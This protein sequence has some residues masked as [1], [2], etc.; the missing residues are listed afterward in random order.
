[1]NE[2]RE[3]AD[4]DPGDTITEERAARRFH[5]MR[6]MEKNLAKLT[7]RINDAADKLKTLKEQRTAQVDAMLAAARDEGDL[8]LFSD[9]D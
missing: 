6:H 3:D 5:Q 9:L 8:P 7:K 4:R 1:M 2:D